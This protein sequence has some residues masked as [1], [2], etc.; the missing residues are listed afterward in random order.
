MPLVLTVEGMTCDGCSN[1]VQRVV[2]RVP[3]VIKAAVSLADK[4]LDIEGAPDRGAVVAAV[5]KAGYKVAEAP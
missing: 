5:E 3:G 1:A 4:R 2:S